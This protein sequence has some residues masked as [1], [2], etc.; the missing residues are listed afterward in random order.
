RY[1]LLSRV[2]ARA[3]ARKAEGSSG[4]EQFSGTDKSQLSASAA[5]HGAARKQCI[6]RLRGER[7]SNTPIIRAPFDGC[8]RREASPSHT[9]RLVVAA[10]HSAQPRAYR[11]HAF[12]RRRR[13]G[14]RLL[15]RADRAP[16]RAERRRARG[17]SVAS[18]S[19]P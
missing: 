19:S 11:F 13:A 7:Q 6:S 15:S 10:V 12:L 18:R 4:D 1:M 2:L 17:A 5:R 3:P 8:S 9:A 14:S 16:E